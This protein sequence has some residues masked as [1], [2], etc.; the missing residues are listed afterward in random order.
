M[1][2]DWIRVDEE[3]MEFGYHGP[4]P[5]M[6]NNRAFRVIVALALTAWS[7]TW[8]QCLLLAATDSRCAPA[9]E[10]SCGSCCCNQC[11]MPPQHDPTCPAE[12]PCCERHETAMPSAA[13][14]VI[15]FGSCGPVFARLDSV[16]VL[17]QAGSSPAVRRR[18]DPPW[19]P[20]ATSLIARR[21]LLLM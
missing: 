7:P 13:R 21:C 8:C 17:F 11:T 2:A 6:L 5:R 4:V 9:E 12:C 15:G 10:T 19:L 1:T 18:G 14:A 20:G 16:G 3:A